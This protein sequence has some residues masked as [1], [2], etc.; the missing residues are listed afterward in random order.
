MKDRMSAKKDAG[1]TDA[2]DLALIVRMG[3][4]A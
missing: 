3:L 4:A 2:A 1:A